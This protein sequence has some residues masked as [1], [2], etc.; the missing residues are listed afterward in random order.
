[1]EA[2]CLFAQVLS[3]P[4]RHSRPIGFTLVHRDGNQIR[5]MPSSAWTYTYDDEGNLTKKSK[6][7]QR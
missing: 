7:R 2:Y 1:M 3:F 6:G 4:W 5:S